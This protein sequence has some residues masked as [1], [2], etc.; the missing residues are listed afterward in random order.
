M[1]KKKNSKG[2]DSFWKRLTNVRRQNNWHKT[3]VLLRDG[4]SVIESVPILVGN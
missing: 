4:L 1:Q 3:T 2:R